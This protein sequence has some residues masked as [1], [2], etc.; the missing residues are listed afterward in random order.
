MNG[1]PDARSLPRAATVLAICISESEPSCMRA[2]P[3]QDEQHD[4]LPVLCATLHHPGDDFTDDRAHRAP[5]EAEYEHAELHCAAVDPCGAGKDRVVH[6][7]RRACQL[8]AVRVRLGIDEAKRIFGD[9]PGVERRPGP[10]VGQ[11]LDPTLCA[12]V[13]VKSASGTDLEVAFEVFFLHG[14]AA[15]IALS[16][17]PFAEGFLLGGVDSR[18]GFCE[19]HHGLW[20]A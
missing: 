9:Q 3:E 7:G 18:L 5:H 2:P 6:A 20:L 4:G 11:E 13:E 14:V 8:D 12:Q 10:F 19:L 1:A 15:G 16:K 17:E